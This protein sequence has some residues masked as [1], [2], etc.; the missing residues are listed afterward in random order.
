MK[1][2]V[3]TFHH[4]DEEYDHLQSINADLLAALE[5]LMVP[6]GINEDWCWCRCVNT[7]HTDDMLEH[8]PECQQ[9]SAAIAKAK[10]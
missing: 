6:R 4:D 8:R 3:R 10:P 7:A 5:A 1:M 2:T 9:A